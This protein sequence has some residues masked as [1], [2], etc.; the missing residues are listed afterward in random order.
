MNE[1]VWGPVIRAYQL[2]W[3]LF[4]FSFPKVIAP[5]VSDIKTDKKLCAWPS[6]R[7]AFSETEKMQLCQL[8]ASKGKRTTRLDAMSTCTKYSLSVGRRCSIFKIRS[9]VR[10]PS[11]TDGNIQENDEK[12]GAKL[13]AWGINHR[14]IWKKNDLPWWRR[15]T[16]IGHTDRFSS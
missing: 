4:L 13:S 9:P 10:R 8:K 7:L 12:M 11:Q 2:K 5:L 15:N 1:S 6:S 3:P 16:H 14:K